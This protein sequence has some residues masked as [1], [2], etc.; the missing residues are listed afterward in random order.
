MN[1]RAASPL[2]SKGQMLSFAF[3]TA[4]PLLPAFPPILSNSQEQV[5]LILSQRLQV[6]GIVSANTSPNAEDLLAPFLRQDGL[7]EIFVTL[8]SFLPRGLQV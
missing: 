1:L 7:E 5:I 3:P 8:G 4:Q 6:V 2:L